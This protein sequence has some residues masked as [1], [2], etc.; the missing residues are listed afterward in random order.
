MIIFQC[1][2]RHKLA[3]SVRASLVRIVGHANIESRVAY[4][5][6]QTIPITSA[7]VM[8]PSDERHGQLCM[9]L[10]YTKQM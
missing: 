9:R 2:S 6:Y 8:F 3:R 1:L 4:A 5:Q 7:H 10:V